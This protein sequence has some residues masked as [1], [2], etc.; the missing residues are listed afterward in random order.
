LLYI[1]DNILT[2]THT[3]STADVL[4]GHFLLTDLLL[5]KINITAKESGIEGRIVIVASDSYK[6]TYR[7]GIRFDKLNDES[8]YFFSHPNYIFPLSM[9]QLSTRYKILFFANYKI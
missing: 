2:C 8:G 5:E 1:K 4:V 9:C 3:C 6:H 7:E